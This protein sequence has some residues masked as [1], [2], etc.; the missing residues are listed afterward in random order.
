LNT[1]SRAGNIGSWWGRFGGIALPVVLT[2]LWPTS[3]GADTGIPMLVVVWPSAWAL[4]IPVVLVEAYVARRLLSLSFA[5]S[6]KLSFIANAWSTFVGIPLGW[7]ALFLIE[8]VG[9]LGLSLLKPEVKGAWLLLSPLF[10]AWLGPAP[11]GWHIYAAAAC[12]CVPF[13]LVSIRVESWSAQKRVPAEQAR[14]WARIANLITY[15]PILCTLVWLAISTWIT[16]P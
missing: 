14:R 8:M 2:T 6:A 1:I 11:R 16:F 5:E 9:G 4:F 15:V 10:A 3:A 13:M 12:L 7:L